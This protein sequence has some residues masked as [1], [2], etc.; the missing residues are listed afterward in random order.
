MHTESLPI[1]FSILKPDLQIT[2]HV[3]VD[4]LIES[5]LECLPHGL[6]LEAP[7][8]L[9]R[10][11]NFIFLSL[12]SKLLQRFLTMSVHLLHAYHTN[13]IDPYGCKAG[14]SLFHNPKRPK[15]KAYMTQVEPESSQALSSSL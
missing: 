6:K 9:V 1:D 4:I 8:G 5:L 13:F 12:M 11:I 2:V 7:Y 14:Q 10:F 3:W 15:P